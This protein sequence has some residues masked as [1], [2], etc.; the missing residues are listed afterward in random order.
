MLVKMDYN[1]I[2]RIKNIL[3]EFGSMSGLLCNVDKTTL[4]P[5]GPNGQLDDRILHTGFVL[6][7]K[8]TILGLELNSDGVTNKNFQCI[9]DK[10]KA[11]I[12]NWTPYK[13][14]LPGRITIAKSLMYSQ[15]N[16][17]GCFLTFPEGFI[18]S[19]DD[20]ITSFVKGKLNVAKKRLYKPVKEGG[21][22]LFKIPNFL[23]AQRCAWIKRSLSLMNNG[24]CSCM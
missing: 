6:V 1:T 11:I 10:I 21:L 3:E 20:S 23:H 18:T 24:K 5:I 15:I 19:I 8:V 7:D 17:L 2:C 9:L 16:Y 13:L 14:S 22:G 4:L 12:A